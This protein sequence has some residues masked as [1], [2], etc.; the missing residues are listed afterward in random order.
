MAFYLDPW[1]TELWQ[2]PPGFNRM[3]GHLM[4]G[5]GFIAF[6]W[7]QWHMIINQDAAN[8]FTL[9]VHP[10]WAGVRHF[11]SLPCEKFGYSAMNREPS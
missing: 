9:A 1:Q 8:N 10:C 2:Q 6:A 11:V 3:G 7:A 4:C 5:H